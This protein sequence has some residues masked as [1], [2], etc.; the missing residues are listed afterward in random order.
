MIL[1]QDFRS[2][3]I[4]DL[5]FIKF[6]CK[7][8]QF[9]EIYVI[10]L[11]TKPFCMK[12]KFT[13]KQTLWLLIFNIPFV[14]FSQQSNNE[15]ST[16]SD[17]NS[18][19]ALYNNK[20]YAAAQEKFENSIKSIPNKSNLKADASYYNAMCAIKLNKPNADKKIIDFVAEYPSSSKRNKAFFNVGNY[21]F[22]NRKTAYALKW[23]QKVTIH[24]LTKELQEEINFKMGYALLVSKRLNLAKEKFLP[25]INDAKYGND[26]RYYYGYIAYKQE[27]Y[28]TAESTLKE[29]ADNA[30]FK[31][32][33]SYYLL[34][35]SFKSGRF[36]RCIT[37]GKKLLK[38][39]KKKEASEIAKIIG[40]SYFNLKKY[41]E[42][43]PYLKS[44]KGKSGKWNNTDYYQLGY[45]YYKENNFNNAV[46]YFNKIID[47]ENAV[48]QNAYY[49]LA[50]CYLILDKKNEALNA[51]KTA[52]NMS[53]NLQIQEDASLNYAKLSYEQG[54]P[55]ENVTDV[56]QNYL[57]KYPNASSYDEINSLIVLSFIHQKNYKEALEY[58]KK[59][60]SKQNLE[61]SEEVSLYRGIE[62][63]NKKNIQD[64]LSY[65]T[66]AK[67][68]KNKNIKIKANYW[69]AET[70]YQLKRYNDALNHFVALEKDLA[71]DKND[72]PLLD[73]N[74]GYCYFKLENYEKAIQYFHKTT[75]LKIDLE[76]IIDDTY[77]R[78]GDSYFALRNY[79]KAI[80]NYNFI[81]DKKGLNSDYAEYQTG[82]SYGFQEQNSLKIK[83]LTNVIN[84]YK[85]S[86]L[87]DDALFE[88]AN[89]YVKENNTTSAHN[90]Y[91]R[92]YTKH[93]SSIF[94]SKALVREGLL[95]YNEDKNSKALERF[96][97]VAKQYPN[98]SDAIEAV[99][100]AKNIYLDEDRLDQYVAWIKELNY[101]EISDTELEK[102]S[103]IIAERKYFKG[104]NESSILSLKKYLKNYPNGKNYLKA[105]YYLANLFYIEKDY[106][107]AK[108]TYQQV[109]K[110]GQTDY[111]EEAL[112]KLSEL[113]LNDGNFKEALKLLTQLELEAYNSENIIYAQSNLMKGYASLYEDSLALRYA[114]KILLKSKLDKEIVLD[115]KLIIARTAFKSN[116]FSTAQ[117]YFKAIEKDAIGILKAESLYYK[118]YFLN[119]EK[120]FEKSNTVVQKLIADYSNYKYWGVKS[121]IIMAKNYYRL[122]D[123]Y[124]A[125]FILENILKNFRQFEDIT[126]EV[127]EVLK[128]I[129]LQESKTNNSVT[130]KNK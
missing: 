123:V 103:F 41:S 122:E 23:Y 127:E 107:E 59:K 48:A 105:T 12:I 92:L 13:T 21:Y 86:S 110:A 88:L 95:Y 79:K 108:E 56:L 97:S 89:T 63:F 9:K 83:A 99:K 45:A 28:G 130:P 34:D 10:T 32:E 2:I 14:L 44:Y 81:I 93:P 115:A 104:K 75:K 15:T 70:T 78:L 29:I 58:L 17:F 49:H 39:V 101:V 8:Q 37:V 109:L 33:I 36:E 94:I 80:S 76:N 31:A 55:F 52:S 77:L 19:L 18:G 65:F 85:I 114:K 53:Y 62:L 106:A 7:C 27:D 60:K 42:A 117:E 54:N 118:A 129:K 24:S 111:S 69:E 43:I 1:E 11:V 30:S 125:T 51:F 64:A 124:Q 82:L 128:N 68:A 26:S 84:Y 3:L 40:E 47:Q 4:F 87:K 66:N 96:K 121:Y 6:Q 71:L 100:N 113:Y 38:T 35:I 126:E 120:S 98:S 91:N 46:S 61:L 20:A 25:L 116:D 72:Y 16:T 112:A 67:S 73:Y 74:I 119:K 90:A 102:S 22:A 50:E 57:K 5:I